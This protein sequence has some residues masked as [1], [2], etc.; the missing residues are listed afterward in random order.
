MSTAQQH[1]HS[2]Q[3]AEPESALEAV[4]QQTGET[5]DVT[6]LSELTKAEIDMK[7]STAKRYPRS[8][9]EFKRKLMEMA[10]L[11][12]E[13]AGSMFYALPRDGK[14]IKGPSV[15]MAEA[16]CSCY[17]NVI[18]GA[19]VVGIDK[20]FVTA[21]G[22]CHDLENNVSNT[23]EIRR[24]IVTSKGKRYNLDMIQTTGNAAAAIAFREATFKVIP[25]SLFKKEYEAAMLTSVGQAKSI[26]ETRRKVFEWWAKSGAPEAKLLAFLGRAGIDDVTLDDLVT[27]RGLGTALKDG[28]ITVEE[29]LEIKDEGRGAVK[30]SVKTLAKSLPTGKPPKQPERASEAAEH[31]SEAVQDAPADEV[32]QEREPGQDDDESQLAPEDEATFR[33]IDRQGVKSRFELF[34]A[35]EEVHA[36]ALY[37]SIAGPESNI[38][39][40]DSNWAANVYQQTLTRLAKADKKTKGGK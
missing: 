23:Q 31:P 37:D 14:T 22:F 18:C 21:Q 1:E 20:E 38:S 16:V 6:V 10:C 3:H 29:A 32:S 40:D 28:E 39:A 4:L 27:L 17:G 13:T 30:E 2:D 8:L 11:D 19:R 25:R 5:V 15:R 24:R 9:K 33:Q 7:I 34:V 36:R 12:E 26:S 35:G